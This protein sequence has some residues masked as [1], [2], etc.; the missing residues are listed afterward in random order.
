MENNNEND[1]ICERCGISEEERFVKKCGECEK[2]MCPNCILTRVT[3]GSGNPV[4]LDCFD[5]N[6]HNKF[7]G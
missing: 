3:D 7:T 1:I 2:N 6:R 4:C 5:I